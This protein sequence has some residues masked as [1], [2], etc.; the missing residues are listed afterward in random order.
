M[1]V[2]VGIEVPIFDRNQGNVTAAVGE[3]RAAQ[4][5]VNRLE[6]VLRDR[7]AEVYQ[8]YQSARNQSTTYRDTILPTAQEN[9]SIAVRAYEA[10]EL[11]FLRVLTARRDLFEARMNYIS[12]MTELRVSAVEIQGMLLTGGLDSVF[13]PATAANGSGQNSGIGN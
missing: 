13:T 3:L 7:L 4:A 9:L 12:A 6:L 11:D 8:R 1:A 5:E 2:N 10:G